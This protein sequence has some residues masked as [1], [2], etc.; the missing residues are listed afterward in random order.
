M[1]RKVEAPHLMGLVHGLHVR[2]PVEGSDLPG[3]VRGVTLV[4]LIDFHEDVNRAVD[5]LIPLWDLLSNHHLNLDHGALAQEIERDHGV[6]VG[7]Q[8]R[9]AVSRWR[10]YRKNVAKRNCPN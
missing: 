5:Y 1:I 6:D 3:Y 10:E 2:Q 8:Y 7:A 9:K 4:L